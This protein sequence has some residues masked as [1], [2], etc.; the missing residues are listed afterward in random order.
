MTEPKPSYITSVA[1]D[2][3]AGER[4][5]QTLKSPWHDANQRTRNAAIATAYFAA[6]TAKATINQGP[7]GE[8]QVVER[9]A[10]KMMNDRRAAIRASRERMGL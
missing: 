6:A 5:L 2:I 4:L 8:Y 1:E 10:A 9:A 3:A 7:P